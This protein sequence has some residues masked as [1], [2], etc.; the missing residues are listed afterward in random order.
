MANV[1]TLTLTLNVTGD[2][3]AERLADVLRVYGLNLS[4]VVEKTVRNWLRKALGAGVD[5]FCE[6]VES[7]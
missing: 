5:V 3:D 6:A 2:V 1:V 7:E 4:R